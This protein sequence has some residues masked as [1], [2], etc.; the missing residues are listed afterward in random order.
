M[1][2][3][4]SEKVKSPLIIFVSVELS[5]VSELVSFPIP[6]NLLVSLFPMRTLPTSNKSGL[7]YVHSTE[8]QWSIV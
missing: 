3:F 4:A 6:K 5:L 2:M 1:V 8:R 7:V